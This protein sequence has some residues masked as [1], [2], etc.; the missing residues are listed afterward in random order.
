[1][2]LLG[3]LWGGCCCW[4]SWAQALIKG[5]WSIRAC[6]ALCCLAVMFCGEGV[7]IRYS[8]FGKHTRTVTIR[9]GA[10]MLAL[11]TSCFGR[12]CCTLLHLPECVCRRR[13]QHCADHHHHS[14]AAAALCCCCWCRRRQQWRADHRHHLCNSCC[15]LLL[16][17]LLLLQAAWGTAR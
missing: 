9:D 11:C 2:S 14:A 13:W 7:T 3:F 5:T 12:G 16:L 15:S 6:L 1:M 10:C 8:M 17:L 4:M